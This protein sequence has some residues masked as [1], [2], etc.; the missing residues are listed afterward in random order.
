MKENLF[1]VVEVGGVALGLYA[2]SFFAFSK[3]LKKQVR[4][5]QKG[6]CDWCGRKVKKLQIHHIIPQSMKGKDTRENAVGLCP[7]CHRYWDE[8][9]LKGVFYGKK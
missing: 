3:E 5:E 6:V 2:L 4:K 1:R 9:S 8:L 7:D